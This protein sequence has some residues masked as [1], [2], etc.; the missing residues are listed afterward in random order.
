[1][2]DQMAPHLDKVKCDLESL[3]AHQILF[4]YTYTGLA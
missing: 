3:F 1:M 2:T 4:Q